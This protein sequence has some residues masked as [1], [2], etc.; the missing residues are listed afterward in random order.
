M[1]LGEKIRAFRT[2]NNMSQQQLA[3]SLSV[4]RQAITKWENNRGI[5]DIANLSALADVFYTS[6]D[7]IMQAENTSGY[8]GPSS[9]CTCIHL[10]MGE[11]FAATM[12]QALNILGLKE[13]QKIITLKEDYSIGPLH[14]LD[15]AK[16]REA[17]SLWFRNHINDAFEEY[18]RYEEAYQE[19]LEQID[20]IPK[21]AKIIIWTAS[22]SLEQIGMRHAIHLL[23]TKENPLV[24]C[25]AY[26][27]CKALNKKTMDYNVSYSGLIQVNELCEIVNDITNKSKKL[28]SNDILCLENEWENIAATDTI[29][30]I[31]QNGEVE[32]VEASYYDN[33]LIKKLKELEPQSD[34]NGFIKSTRLIGETMGSC[35]QYIG[36]SYL[37]YR[38]RE[39]IYAGIL[40][41]KGVPKAMRYYSV[42]RK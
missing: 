5:P 25:D 41:I 22:N 36:D 32:N 7:E 23:C 3:D 1:N 37:E 29:L 33:L 21:L 19:L 27:I 8:W 26:E 12:K 4:S 38:L 13:T 15:S 39:M 42:R 31:W 28:D 40:E 35:N 10:V 9:T 20:F 6:I 17:R 14:N 30:R 18:E 24:V 34:D 11:S 2:E 16:G